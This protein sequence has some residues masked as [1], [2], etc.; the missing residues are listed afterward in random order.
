MPRII[1]HGATA[2]SFANVVSG[3]SSARSVLGS[4]VPARKLVPMGVRR[5]VSRSI[6]TAGWAPLAVFGLHAVLSVTGA[7]LTHPA[8]DLPMH[9]AG[10]VV[11]AYFFA[12]CLTVAMEEGLLGTPDAFAV[13][14][15]TFTCTCAAAVLWEF[16]EW[17]HDQFF[18]ARDARGYE[19][20]LLDLA[21]GIVGGAVFVAA[22]AARAPR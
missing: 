5:V 15:L 14:L 1:H 18:M 16:V 10:G 8:I 13:A 2:G 6:R 4:S 9:L 19:D 12:R 20:T 7:Y 17:T 3:L 22:A 21:L 11:I